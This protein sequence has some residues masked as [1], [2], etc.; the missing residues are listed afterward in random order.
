MK[1]IFI[2][3]WSWI[4]LFNRKE[5]QHQQ[6]SQLYQTFREVG[7]TIITTDYILDEVDTM[8]FKRVPVNAAQK[9]I[10]IMT[11]AVEQG[12]VNLIWITPERFEAAQKLRTDV[13]QRRRQFP[14]WE[15]QGV[16]SP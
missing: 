10:K 9:A 5:R 14:S 3:T 8:L 1:T 7:R 2:D 11:T 12:Y 16:G 13:T 15:G 6:V 4:N